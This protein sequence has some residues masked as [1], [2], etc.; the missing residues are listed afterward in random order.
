MAADKLIP[1]NANSK[2]STVFLVMF[3]HTCKHQH[4]HPS[5]WCEFYCP[6]EGTSLYNLSLQMNLSH[7]YIMDVSL[8]WSPVC[9]IIHVMS[10]LVVEVVLS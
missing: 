10:Y 5:P 3:L 9:V 2:S 4:L 7:C 1:H 8:I 6:V